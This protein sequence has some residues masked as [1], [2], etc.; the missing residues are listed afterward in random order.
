MK[1]LYKLW[2]QEWQIWANL[3]KNHYVFEDENQI[4]GYIHSKHFVTVAQITAKKHS[5][6]LKDVLL[7]CWNEFGQDWQAERAGKIYKRYLK[8]NGFL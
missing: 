1:E 3:K 6:P 8:Y 4:D 7:A 5:V 2:Y